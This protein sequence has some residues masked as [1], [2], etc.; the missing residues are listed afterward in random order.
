MTKHV[1]PSSTGQPVA[2]V[3]S[4]T[5]GLAAQQRAREKA[6]LRLARL[7]KKAMAEIER[8]ISFLDQ[9]DPYVMT[10]AEPDDDEPSLGF[11]EAFPGRGAGGAG[12]DRELDLGTFDRLINQEPAARRFDQGEELDTADAEPSLGSCNGWGGDP[13][14]Q[15]RWACGSQSDREDDPTES[16]IADHDGLL[17]QVGS[18]FCQPGVLA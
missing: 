17:E 8:L 7:R 3:E 10:E 4:I 2:V 9:S 6:L 14:S 1:P 11:Q 5:A 13:V 12:D 15:E 16:G 18:Q